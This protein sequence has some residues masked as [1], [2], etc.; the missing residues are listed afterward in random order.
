MKKTAFTVLACLV[1]AAAALSCQRKA[2][3]GRDTIAYV[4]GVVAD[5]TGRGPFSLLRHFDG[6]AVEAAIAVIGEPEASL[7]L[8]ERLRRSD[9]FDNVDGRPVPDGLPDFAGEVIAAYL[10]DANSPYAGFLADGRETALRETAV[11][12]FFFALDTV[13]RVTPFDRDHLR[14]K[15]GAKVVILSSSLMSEYGYY[16]LD[17][18]IRLGGREVPLISPVHTLLSAAFDGTDGPLHIGV[19]AD[20]AVLGSGAYSYVFNALRHSRRDGSTLTGFSP[21][22]IGTVGDRFLKFLDMYRDAGPGERLSVLLVDDYGV[23]LAQLDKA[24]K[25]IRKAET[26]ETMRYNKLLADDFRFIGILDAIDAACY[27]LMRRRNL[28]THYVAYPRVTR[29]QTVDDGPASDDP[30]TLI[31]FN[32]KFLSPETVSAI[33]NV[34]D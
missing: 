29:Y 34:Q 19:W 6:T 23:D 22:A 5:S 21:E 11:R 27:T 2:R 30:F 33:G 3:T 31:E 12:D 13:C 26:F 17:T 20:R 15:S 32:P 14:H 25:E 7:L 8:A 4:H 10:D 9:G 28:F 18:L 16:D 24:L 1:V